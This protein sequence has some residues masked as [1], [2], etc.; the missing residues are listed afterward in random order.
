[1]GFVPVAPRCGQVYALVND[2]SAVCGAVVQGK[3]I[4]LR[5]VNQCRH[6]SEVPKS[7]NLSSNTLYLRAA[8]AGTL[9]TVYALPKVSVGNMTDDL[10]ESLLDMVT[11]DPAFKSYE[12]GFLLSFINKENITNVEEFVAALEDQEEGNRV[13][14]RTP[15]RRKVK[16]LDRRTKFAAEVGVAEGSLG[17]AATPLPTDGDFVS[18]TDP[19][20]EAEILSTT[21]LFMTDVNAVAE[22]IESKPGKW[23][24]ELKEYGSDSWESKGH[25]NF[26][27]E[28]AS[29]ISGLK[30]VMPVGVVVHEATRT[31]FDNVGKLETALLA[32]R[33]V[34][35]SLRFG[36]GDTKELPE[37]SGSSIVE[38]IIAM[39]DSLVGEKAV[40]ELVDALVD[41]AK[42]DIRE[43]IN[44]LEEKVDR[45]VT[46]LQEEVMEGIQNLVKD[47]ESERE[48]KRGGGDGDGRKGGKKYVFDGKK[49]FSEE[50]M[51]AVVASK[52]D[53][54]FPIAC[55][56][57]PF[58]FFE[59]LHK[60]LYDE[61][62]SSLTDL[63][64]AKTLGMEPFD[65]WAAQG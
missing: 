6:G 16:A 65:Y 34:V 28:L 22:A 25:K 26:L 21:G 50:D 47:L 5:S 59:F 31:L 2:R 29:N 58:I 38:T 40:V 37:G 14:L 3:K 48:D 53:G 4:C 12:P 35:S 15:A 43:E 7:E 45:D 10:K 42:I 20:P 17:G 24:E 18:S 30:V 23:E 64:S 44:N 46:N 41:D 32:H 13:P 36:I 62:Q 39:Q 55:F 1:M 49:I 51:I 19:A 27:A 60:T 11:N 61:L 8:S 54:Y 52:S 56:P 9:S 63:K 57:S 33:N